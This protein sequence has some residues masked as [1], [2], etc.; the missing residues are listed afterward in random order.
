[1]LRLGGTGMNGLGLPRAARRPAGMGL[2]T[3]T[4]IAS[5]S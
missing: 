2:A 4:A 3:G 5:V 1:M